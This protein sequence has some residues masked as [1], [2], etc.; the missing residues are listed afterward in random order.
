MQY[1][2]LILKLFAYGFR[3]NSKW[4]YR[5]TNRFHLNELLITSKYWHGQKQNK[6]EDPFSFKDTDE[7]YEAVESLN[8]KNVS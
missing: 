5:C 7:M 8:P 6:I 2:T 3:R 4:E 1:K